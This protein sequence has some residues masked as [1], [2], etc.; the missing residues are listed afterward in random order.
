MDKTLA[1]IIKNTSLAVLFIGATLVVLGASGTNGKLGVTL[2]NPWQIVVALFGI[3]LT[4]FGGLTVQS[5]H[6]SV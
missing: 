5:L 4:G 3:V 2:A 6:T 1:S